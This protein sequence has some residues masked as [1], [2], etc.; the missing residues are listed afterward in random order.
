MARGTPFD[1]LTALVLA[2]AVRHQHLQEVQ[3]VVG[4][5]DR[6]QTGT[7][8]RCLVPAGHDD[9]YAGTRVC[10]YHVSPY[11]RSHSSRTSTETSRRYKPSRLMVPV[12]CPVAAWRHA[13]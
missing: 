7:D 9:R 12:R 3:G 2:P 5:D 1:D 4:G 13:R 6:V 8:V 11:S 10:S